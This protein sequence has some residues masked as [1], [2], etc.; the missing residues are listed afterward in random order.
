MGTAMPAEIRAHGLSYHI[1]RRDLL[2]G[3][4]FSIEPAL[5][6]G[7]WIVLADGAFANE[8]E[9]EIRHRC[10][11][12]VQVS[13]ESLQ[14]ILKHGARIAK[15]AESQ[16]RKL[17]SNGAVD[18]TWWNPPMALVVYCN[19]HECKAFSIGNALIFIVRNGVVVEARD[20]FE[21]EINDDLLVTDVDHWREVKSFQVLPN[22]RILVCSRLVAEALGTETAVALMVGDSFEMLASQVVEGVLKSGS[23]RQ[24]FSVVVC[25]IMEYA[26]EKQ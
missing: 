2:H 11:E 15:V 3:S 10:R 1:L 26:E 9:A 14:A 20:A 16:Q 7:S 19:G 5:T 12:I 22:D 23:G 21:S 25:E 6:H 13:N 18:E 17:T 24:P 4:R 8:I